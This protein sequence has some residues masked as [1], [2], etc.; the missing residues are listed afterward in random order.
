MLAWASSSQVSG[1][2]MIVGFGL[3]LP[4]LAS[5]AFGAGN[6]RR[7]GDLLQRQLMLHLLLIV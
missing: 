7:V 1:V 2:S 6:Y 3:G 5:H 4:P